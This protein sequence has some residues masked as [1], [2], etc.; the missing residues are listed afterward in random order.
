[1]TDAIARHHDRQ[2]GQ[3][4]PVLDAVVIANLVAKNIGV[5]LGAEGFT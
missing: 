5:G 1:V 4:T 3:S 2:L